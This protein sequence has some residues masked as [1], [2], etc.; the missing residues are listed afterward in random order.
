[1]AADESELI[2]VRCEQCCD[3]RAQRFVL[4]TLTLKPSRTVVGRLRQ[5]QLEEKFFA[6][7]FQR[8]TGLFF[9]ALASSKAAS[10]CFHAASWSGLG[11]AS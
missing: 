3:A 10:F 6:V 11:Q 2:V 7:L 8:W 5:R 1:M 9:F 4:A